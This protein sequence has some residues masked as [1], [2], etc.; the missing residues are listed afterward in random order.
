MSPQAILYLAALVAATVAASICGTCLI[1]S[2]EEG[3]KGEAWG[4][5]VLFVAS[6]V[7]AAYYFFKLVEGRVA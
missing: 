6:Y 2:I 4:W 7:V 1:W 3:S 5:P